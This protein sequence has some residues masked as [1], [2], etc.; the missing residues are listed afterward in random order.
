MDVILPVWG[1][2]NLRRKI[3]TEAKFKGSKSILFKLNIRWLQKWIYL[4]L[5]L[6]LL[7]NQGLS[8]SSFLKN[9][10]YIFYLS[11]GS[12]L[13]ETTFNLCTKE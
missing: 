2:L 6:R 8:I 12:I 1:K 5:F 3:G 10:T 13:K 9:F 7:C 11:S 4:F